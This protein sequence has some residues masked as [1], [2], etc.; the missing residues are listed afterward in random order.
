LVIDK[1]IPNVYYSA[2]AGASTALV[3][4]LL[5]PSLADLF[6][7]CKKKIFFEDCVD[8]C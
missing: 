8:D 5:G 1:G 6:V 7:L 3:M 4:A 2:T